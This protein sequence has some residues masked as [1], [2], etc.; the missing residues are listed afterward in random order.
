LGTIDVTDDFLCVVALMRLRPDVRSKSSTL[1][2]LQNVSLVGPLTSR[3]WQQ[4]TK[5]W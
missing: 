2:M 3:S 1:A 5:L 4:M